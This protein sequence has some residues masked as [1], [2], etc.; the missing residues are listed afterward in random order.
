MSTD[1]ISMPKPGFSIYSPSTLRLKRMMVKS[2]QK[3]M[4]Q[5]TIAQ[6]ARVIFNSPVSNYLYKHLLVSEVLWNHEGR[7]VIFPGNVDFFSTVLKSNFTLDGKAQLNL[8]YSSFILAMP[9]NFEVDGVRIPSVIVHYSKADNRR[10]RYDLATNLMALPTMVHVDNRV[11]RDDCLSFFYHDTY[12]EDGVVVQ[13]TQTPSQIA[14]ALK[15]NTSDEY[16][17]ILGTMP[18]DMVSPIALDLSSSDYTIQF[19]IT[20][21]IAG[22]AVYMSANSIEQLTDGLPNN[23]RVVINNLKKDVKYSFSHLPLPKVSINTGSSDI[24]TTRSFHFRQLRAPI[25]YRN[26]YKHLEPG[27]RWVFVKAAQVGKYKAEHIT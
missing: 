15:A 25:Y 17:E 12:S 4:K 2:G 5:A 22:I 1:N 23:G 27:S 26:E 8:P 13:A 18:K 6:V 7:K 16:A 20:K 9:R 21:I 10:D 14:S 24:M 19:A 11:S 3:H